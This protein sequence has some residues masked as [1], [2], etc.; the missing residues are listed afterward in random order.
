VKEELVIAKVKIDGIEILFEDA[1]H[2]LQIE[3]ISGAD[4]SMIW[5]QII[6]TYGNYD[7]W[8][9][10]HNTDG[11]LDLLEEL[12]AVLEDDCIEMRLYADKINYS[13]ALR[14]ERVTDETFGEFAALHDSRISDMYWTGERLGRDLSKWGIFCLRTDGQITDY[15]I[16]SMRHPAEA[17]IFCVEASDSTRCRELFAFASKYAFDNGKNYVL[18]MADDAMRHDA[19]LDVGFAVTGFYKGYVVRGA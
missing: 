18:Y 15:T 17:E 16:M 10:F 3:D 14:V 2:Y 4:L 6:A 1:D 8:L 11:P 19:A 5:E 9:C 13:E 12:G 7:K